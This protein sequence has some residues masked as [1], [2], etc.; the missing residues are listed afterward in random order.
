MIKSERKSPNT[1]DHKFISACFIATLENYIYGGSLKQIASVLIMISIISGAL[2]AAAFEEFSARAAA[3][4]DDTAAQHKLVQ[5]YL[6][7][8]QTVDEHR[9]LQDFWATFDPEACQSHYQRLAQAN[10]ANPDY[11]YLSIRLLED[12]KEEAYTLVQKHPKFY[13]GYRLVALRFT[14]DIQDYSYL[15]TDDYN[16]GTKIIDKGLKEFPEDDYLLLAQTYR[17]SSEGKLNTALSYLEKL[18]DANTIQSNYSF[19]YDLCV[20]SGSSEVYGS[21]ID[22]LMD[23]AIAAGK[24]DEK[25]AED[26]KVLF[27][28]SFIYDSAG[29]EAMEHYISENPAVTENGEVLKYLA[30]SYFENEDPQQALEYLRMAIELGAL[31]YPEMINSPQYS[32]FE[33]NP[34]WNN[35]LT[36]AKNTYDAEAPQRE[37]ALLQSRRVKPATQWELKDINGIIHKSDDLRGQ[38]IILDFWAQWC[39]PCKMT[40]P[41]LS[42]WVQTK[43]PEGVKVYS[44]NVMDNDYDRAIAYF[45]DNEFA[46][47]YLE[48]TDSLAAEYGVEAIPHI[49]VIDKQG[50]IAWEQVGF[51]FDLEEKLSFWA[52]YLCAE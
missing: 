15:Y 45:R 36:Q 51:S 52:D 29:I 30:D 27:V 18:K 8:A 33:S 2:W 48:G 23:S 17:Y 39:G 41:A 37:A 16:K 31:Q 9:T 6:Y 5:E 13:W 4:Q 24:I 12:N 1:Q 28:L 34:E 47:E 19:I 21:M 25:Q 32:Y 38:V 14:Q 20:Q 3:I 43:M 46:M 35:L 22:I 26:S 49:V 40:M 11:A 44:V 50:N 7:K 10:P 42:N